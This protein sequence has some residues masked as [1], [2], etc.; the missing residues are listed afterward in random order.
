MPPCAGR[1]LTSSP[2]WHVFAGSRQSSAGLSA[3][4]SEFDSQKEEEVPHLT[5]SVG[6]LSHLNSGIV[7]VYLPVALLPLTGPP[8]SFYYLCSLSLIELEQFG[9]IV[10]F[11]FCLFSF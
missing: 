6:R 1:R 10:K 7:S 9:H 4:D 8:V 11:A 2:S 5:I 3:H